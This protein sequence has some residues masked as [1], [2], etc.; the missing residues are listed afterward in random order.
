MAPAFASMAWHV[1]IGWYKIDQDKSCIAW[2]G[3]GVK[4]QGTPENRASKLP[5]KKRT[6]LKIKKEEEE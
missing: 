6:K 1:Y 3:Y 4:E 2:F 5:K